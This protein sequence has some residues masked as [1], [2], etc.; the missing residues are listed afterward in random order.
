MNKACPWPDLIESKHIAHFLLEED[1]LPDLDLR[2]APGAAGSSFPS[3]DATVTAASLRHPPALELD[4]AGHRRSLAAP[5]PPSPSTRGTCATQRRRASALLTFLHALSIRRRRR[6]VTYASI[7]LDLARR[8]INPALCSA[9]A[10]IPA[11]PATRLRRDA[12]GGGGVW[13]WRGG[14]TTLETG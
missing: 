14:G 10:L 1:L 13:D 12:R 5:P 3:A 8:P 9:A 2:S 11:A 6:N 7:L 4:D